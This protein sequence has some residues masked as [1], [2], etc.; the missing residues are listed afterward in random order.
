M[1][2]VIVL[3]E[4]YL[5]IHTVLIG[6]KKMNDRLKNTK[7]HLVRQIKEANKSQSDWVYILKSE[8][9]KCLELAE[10]EDR[11]TMSPVIGEW[12]GSKNNWWYVCGECHTHI[13]PH[14]KYCHECGRK[15]K[16]LG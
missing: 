4:S 15:V 11:F 16:F 1:N 10:E 6:R 13:N 12:E 3:V 5:K 9:E 2:H 7:K 8:A 14:D